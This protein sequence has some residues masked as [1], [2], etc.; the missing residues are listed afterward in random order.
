M[1]D[2]YELIDGDDLE[3]FTPVLQEKKDEVN[4]VLYFFI[5][6]FF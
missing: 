2:L 1:G 4:R 5:S 6:V 3:A